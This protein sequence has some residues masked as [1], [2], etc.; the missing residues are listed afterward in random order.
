MWLEDLDISESVDSWWKS[1]EI[2]EKIQEAAKKAAE[3]IKKVQKDEQ[4]AK[5]QDIILARFLVEIIKN[6]NYDFLLNDL[7]SSIKNWYTWN[8]LI[9]LLSLIYSPISVYIRD[10]LWKEQIKFNYKITTEKLKF[11]DHKIDIEI[12][13]RINSWI[14]DIIDITLYD[15]WNIQ[16]QKLITTYEENSNFIK[17]EQSSINSLW[18][19]IFQYFFYNLNI[20]ISNSKASSY[21]DFILNQIYKNIKKIK[22]DDL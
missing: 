12:Q 18:I 22:L 15:F 4:K 10:T 11:D 19:I 5:K 20:D 14:E 6:N 21:V 2:I 17:S 13:N 16:L 9:W 8:F 7:L 1:Q 3:R